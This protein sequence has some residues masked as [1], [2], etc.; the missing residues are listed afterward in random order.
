MRFRPRQRL[1]RPADF[2]A[3]RKQ[4]RRHFGAAFVF[5]FRRQPPGPGMDLPRFAV[6]APRRIGPAVTRNLLKRRL[7]E[8]FRQHQTLFPAGTDLV[9]VLQ[10]KAAATPFAGLEH[11]FLDAARRAGFR[12]A[13]PPAELPMASGDAR[14]DLSP[15]RGD[16]GSSSAPPRA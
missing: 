4:G 2:A 14:P 10:P 1:R 5:S 3:V 11:E 7:R 12:P 6:V 16:G 9:V 8:I 15:P 13:T